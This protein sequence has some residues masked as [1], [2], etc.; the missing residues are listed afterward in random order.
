MSAQKPGLRD[1]LWTTCCDVVVLETMHQFVDDERLS[2]QKLKFLD[3]A[4]VIVGF[5]A[6]LLCRD[7]QRH[8]LDAR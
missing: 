3:D 4:R 1:W 8:D 7:L 2:G 5:D 6:D